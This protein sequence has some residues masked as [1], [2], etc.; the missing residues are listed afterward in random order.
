[1]EEGDMKVAASEKH[2]L[3]EK[4][5]AL[6]R[7]NEEMQVIHKAHYF[8]EV[9]DDVT[10]EKTFKFKG[11]YWNKREVGDWRGAFDLF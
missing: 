8:N 7:L 11:E 6:R 3:E 10:G 4:Q 5:R 1:M 9:D 2:R